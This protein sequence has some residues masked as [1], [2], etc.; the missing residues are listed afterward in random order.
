M[1]MGNGTETPHL[2]GMPET[3]PMLILLM[4]LAR[5]LRHRHAACRSELV[6]AAL[7]RL[8]TP[9]Q[10]PGVSVPRPVAY[11]MHWLSA[12]PT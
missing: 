7:F 5:L 10:H 11:G 9:L 2:P 1:L 6:R 12:D 3:V 4:L 8:R